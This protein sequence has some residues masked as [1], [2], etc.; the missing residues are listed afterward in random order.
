MDERLYEDMEGNKLSLYKMVRQEPNWAMS[1][2]R[3]CEELEKEIETLRHKQE[4]LDAETM[5]KETL[6]KMNAKLVQK[7]E[8]LR[9]ELDS[10]NRKINSEIKKA[11]RTHAQSN[12]DRG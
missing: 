7:I 8:T 6:Q 11:P 12:K 10:V 9:L 4:E 5:L 2:I 1:R 3:V